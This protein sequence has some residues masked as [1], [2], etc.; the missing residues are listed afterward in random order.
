MPRPLGPIRLLAGCLRKNGPVHTARVVWDALCDLQFDLRNGTDT[1]SWM[2]VQD[3]DVVGANKARGTRYGPTLASPF[4]RLLRKLRLPTDCAF[5]DLG[6]GKGRALMLA[7][8]YGFRRVVGVEFSKELCEAAEGNLACYQDRHHLQAEISILTMDVVDYEFQRDDQVVYMFDPFD[9][10]VTTQVLG[11][12]RKSLQ[13]WP[14]NVWLIYQTP[15][16]RDVIAK[17]QLFSTITEHSIGS[18]SFVVYR[19]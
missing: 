14:R 5:V 6:C 9:E 2:D 17:T 16:H 4:R 13:T 1:F 7:M 15:A 10:V 12:L 19:H 18:C 11:N 8:E 3:L